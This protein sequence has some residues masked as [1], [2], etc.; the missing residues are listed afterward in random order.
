[1]SVVFKNNWKY[2]G[3]AID[4]YGT[5][6]IRNSSGIIDPLWSCYLNGVQIISTPPFQ[7]EENNWHM[8]GIDDL[9][10]MNHTFTLSVSTFGQTFWF[11]Y[12]V[13]TPSPNATLQNDSVV[14]VPFSD[15]ALVYDASWQPWSNLSIITRTLNAVVEFQF[16]GMEISSLL[17]THLLNKF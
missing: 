3:T 16:L 12:L 1:M 6:D 8:C 10:D 15:A 2:L 9:L 4:I 5:N 17:S 7:F 13:Y 11:D 14:L